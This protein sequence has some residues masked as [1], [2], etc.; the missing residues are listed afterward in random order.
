MFF[1]NLNKGGCDN[2][3]Y[4]VL[5][6]EKTASDSEIKKSYRKLAM[7]YHPDRN[8]T[9]KEH[10]ETKFKA[11]SAAYEI[12]SDKDKRKTYDLHGIDA[13]QQGGGDG[14]NP[15][16]IFSNLFGGGGGMRGGGVDPSSFFSSNMNSYTN[17]HRRKARDRVEPIKVTTKDIFIEKELTINVKKR[18]IIDSN[19]IKR[20]DKCDGTGSITSIRNMGPGMIVQSS[21]PCSA[22][23]GVGKIIKMGVKKKTISLKLNNNM[24]SGSKIIFEGDA[25]EDPNADIKGDLIFL[26]E[27]IEDDIFKRA[28]NNDLIIKKNI[29][30]TEALC[31]LELI[32]EHLDDRKL[33]IK[34]D[35]VITP[36]MKKR[37]ISEGINNQG[38]LVIDF[39][40]I[41]P[42]K[43]SSERKQYI[44][45]LLPYK[46]ND[47]NY[48]DC[49]T[50]NMIE[51]VEIN[52]EN[53]TN[54]NRDYNLDEETENVSCAQQ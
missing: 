18:V 22:C 44:T 6:V 30:L 37:I 40:I 3:L 15:F 29:L 34:T 28:D 14:V 39:N 5:N 26:I 2:K 16:D 12:L 35:D 8:P 42:N 11:I 24:K 9:N 49:I 10:S 50:V 53:S 32:I 19:E 13:I 43:I 23:N 48:T 7:K 47:L 1:D 51:C 20:C 52:S 21:Q 41:F 4:S 25:H 46:K 17:T 36:N 31:G 33:L 38:D 27:E 54:F 45:K